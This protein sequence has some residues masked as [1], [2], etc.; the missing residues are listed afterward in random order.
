MKKRVALL[1]CTGSIGVSTQKVL[2]RGDFSVELLLNKS[3]LNG[4]KKL[5]AKYDPK[6]AVCLDAKYYYR[7]GKE[8]RLPDDFSYTPDLFADVDAV[9]NGIVGL[10]GLRPSL[11][12]IGADKILCTANKE[13]FVCAGAIINAALKQSS[14]KI[15]PLDSEHSAV[16]QLLQGGTAEKIYLTASGGAFRDLTK[17]EL[18]SA[19]AVDALKH[20]NWKM[21]KKVTI[22]CATLVN[23]GMELIEAKHLFGLPTEAIGHRESLVHAFVR[24]SDG[25][26]H[27]NL[28]APD[29]VSPISYALHYPDRSALPL[30]PLE[31]QDLTD[32]HFFTLD[33][34]RFPALRL[35]KKAVSSGDIAGCVLNAADEV[36]VDAYLRDEIGFYDVSDGIARAMDRFADEGDFSSIDAVFRMDAA[37]REYTHRSISGGKA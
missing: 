32:L 35:A 28:S 17:E 22:D 16:W 19:K 5:I 18:R 34:D 30:R 29:M 9:V 6:T 11:A 10:A 21:G 8:Y 3:D 20:P 24:Y 31:P 1:G 15:Y 13:S 36:L 7:N 14:A 37:V 4:L 12:A 26:L 23:K 33:E 2:D 25:T 27:A